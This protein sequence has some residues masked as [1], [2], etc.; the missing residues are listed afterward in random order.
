MF[1]LFSC[2]LAFVFV[3]GS[4][5]F[6]DDADYQLRTW[7]SSSG[8]YEVQATLISKTDTEVLLKREDGK[9]VAVPI[10]R[11][12]EADQLY[13]KNVDH[14]SRSN[15]PEIDRLKQMAMQFYESLRS[16]DRAEAR[17]LLTD[18]ARKLAE[19]K[20]SVLA[21]LPKPDAGSRGLRVGKVQVDGDDAEITVTVKAAGE[22][23]KTT[24]HLIRN[25][26]NDWRVFAISAK[27]GADE[28]TLNFEVP[29]ETS[30]SVGAPKDTIAE[31]MGKPVQLTGLT[32]EGSPVSL[33]QYRGK[34]VL[35]DFWA[36]WCGPCR[37][38][39]PIFWTTTKNITIA[40]LMCWQS[41]STKTW[42]N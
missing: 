2:S 40:V 18:D 16:E 10:S 35:I 27:L 29:V 31:L 25:E 24:L 7:K 30:G 3:A 34:V 36:T 42:R 13:L 1:H 14:K 6:N 21:K 22:Q 41:A 9:E 17:N 4:L 26:E 20:K 19:E 39:I 28:H 32:L 8:T 23:H 33:E 37:A 38:E 5:W 12:S 11:L 15:N